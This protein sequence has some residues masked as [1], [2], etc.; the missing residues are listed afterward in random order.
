MKTLTYTGMTELRPQGDYENYRFDFTLIANDLIGLPEEQAN[1]KRYMMNV[2][3]SGTM[4]ACWMANQQGID[5]IKVCYEYSKRRLIDLIRQG[6][7]PAEYQLQIYSNTHQSP[8][9]FDSSKINHQAG[10]AFVI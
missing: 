10:Q 7:T 3:I 1:T 6:A 2:K 5:I 9:E 4:V 8:C